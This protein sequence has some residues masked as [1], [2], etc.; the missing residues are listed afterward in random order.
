MG[1]IIK[2]IS[3]R[4]TSKEKSK[5]VRCY[6]DTG[7]SRTFIKHSVAAQFAG[8]S[9]LA[10][11]QIFHGLGN[12]S[13]FA[14]EFINMRFKILDMWV[15]HLCYVVPDATLGSEYDILVGHDFMQIYDIHLQL[16]ARN[17]KVNKGALKMAM[18]VHTLTRRK[19]ILKVK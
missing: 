11:P 4:S 17:I 13:F 2:K 5:P 18:K 9:E 14:M 8:L 12:G 16:K 1:D 15:P 3:I 6:F 19:M 7:S 10:E